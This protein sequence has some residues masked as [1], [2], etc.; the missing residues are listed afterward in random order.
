MRALALVALLLT[1]SGASATILKLSSFDIVDGAGDELL[2]EDWAQT[3]TDDAD[4]TVITDV[5]DADLVHGA[6]NGGSASSHRSLLVSPESGQTTYISLPSGVTLNSSIVSLG[7]SMHMVDPTPTGEREIVSFREG[8]NRGCN[9]RVQSDGTIKA[10]YDTEL[11]QTSPDPFWEKHCIAPYTYIG[12]S[13][14]NDCKP[15]ALTCVAGSAYW[16]ELEFRQISATTQVACD[17]WWYG[18]QQWTTAYETSPVHT[19]ANVTD[20]RIGAPGAESVAIDMRIDDVVLGT[21]EAVGHGFVGFSVPNGNGST[22]PTNSWTDDTCG[23]S[24]DYDCE[25]D[26]ASAGIVGTAVADVLKAALVNKVATLEFTNPSAAELD[27]LT[28]SAVEWDVIGRTST[29]KTGTWTLTGRVQTCTGGACALLAAVSD[30]ITQPTT[31][32]NVILR[33]VEESAPSGQ[34]SV[35]EL[36]N[37][38]T[39]LTLSATTVDSSERLMLSAIGMQYAARKADITEEVV[40]SDHDE[41]ADDGERTIIFI[42][43]S[44]LTGTQA[45]GCTND[46]SDLCNQDTFCSWDEFP[47]G[48][49]DLP[50]GGCTT[51]AQCRTCIEDGSTPR[52]GNAGAGVPCTTNTQCPQS[53]GNPVGALAT[54]NTTDSE[55]NDNPAIP[56]TTDAHCTGWGASCDTTA[57]CEDACVGGSCPSSSAYGSWGKSIVGKVTVDNIIAC[58]Q[59]GE[60]TYDMIKNRWAGIL[61]GTDAT[62]IVVNGQMAQPD[63]VVVLEGGNEVA[64]LGP[65]PTCGE[66]TTVTYGTL[67][68]DNQYGFCRE[69][70]TAAERDLKCTADSDCSSISASS[71]CVGATDVNETSANGYACIKDNVSTP[72]LSFVCSTKSLAA[73][74]I[75]PLALLLGGCNVDADC[76]GGTCSIN[77]ATS[78]HYGFCLCDADADC[79]DTAV[80]DCTGS[81]CRRKCTVDADCLADGVTRTGAC[82]DL[83]ATDVCA[84][85][86]TCPCNARACTSDQDCATGT[87][88]T[89]GGE[90]FRWEPAGKCV[91]GAC[92]ECG[93]EACPTAGYPY[94]F[95]HTIRTLSPDKYADMLDWMRDALAALPDATN[96]GRPIL[97]SVEHPTYPQ[98]GPGPACTDLA[99]AFTD[100]GYLRSGSARAV[101]RGHHVV[102]GVRDAFEAY[103]KAQG[104]T[105]LETSP[106][107]VQ[108]VDKPNNLFSDFVH[109]SVT[110]GDLISDLIA[111]YIN[112]LGACTVGTGVNA[113]PQRYCLNY[114]SDVYA[115]TGGPNSDG[116]CTES[117]QCG[118]REICALRP[119]TSNASCPSTVT[120]DACRVE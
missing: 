72:A 29:N 97:I 15:T 38:E 28:L 51:D 24:N 101:A 112:T 105:R 12:C 96:D 31:T 56:C 40:L 47:G 98:G 5:A 4:L 17:L 35:T 16:A 46:A 54:C 100:G 2:T 118:A 19:P 37:A 11:L 114:V 23:T 36:T 88:R 18:R 99:P 87:V 90:W 77:D 111:D 65:A 120:G 117:A 80:W 73:P 119:C 79:G 95:A 64:E 32:V 58:G 83:G 21:E 33:N 10:Y 75:D 68:R 106:N 8:A 116:T 25:D 59:G 34:W 57:T 1:A 67:L 113:T 62:C 94:A 110:G 93:P 26:Y 52:T 71:R 61:A 70:C 89:N 63:Y 27:G 50:T 43:D 78:R 41:G 108:L 91:A 86:C 85:R 45:V 107:P 82:V 44:L 22:S 104:V 76:P 14:N 60:R 48:F 6:N 74:D 102:T 7:L 115:T 81:Q 69:N 30:T 55:C 9:W 39:L 20:V 109:F 49:E 103:G 84:G 42:G 13:V 66:S 92:T 53:A 3:T